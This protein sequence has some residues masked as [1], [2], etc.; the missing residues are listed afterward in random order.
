MTKTTKSALLV[1]FFPFVIVS[2]IFAGIGWACV[3]GYDEAVKFLEK[4]R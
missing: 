3:V 4:L 1:V 2:G